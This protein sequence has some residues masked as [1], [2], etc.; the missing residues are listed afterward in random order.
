MFRRFSEKVFGALVCRGF[1]FDP[2]RPCLGG[3]VCQSLVLLP[4]SAKAAFVI[5]ETV[6]DA[7]WIVEHVNGRVDG[8]REWVGVKNQ[9]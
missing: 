4:R 6:D 2:N 8:K 5:M 3:V 1:L 9:V 7:K